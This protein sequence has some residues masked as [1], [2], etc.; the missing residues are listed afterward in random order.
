VAHDN[1]SAYEAADRF[2]LMRV[3]STS[4]L[5]QTAYQFFSGTASAPAWVSYSNRAQ[6][7]AIFT[8]KGRCLRNGMTYH[9]ARKRYY[10]WQQ[11]PPTK[12]DPDTRL[13]GGFGIYSAANP[14]GPWSPVYYTEKW[15]VGPGDRGEFPTK[16]MGSQG[17]N[18]SGD[19]YLSFS[20]NDSFSI[21]KGTISANH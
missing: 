12:F 4:I 8:C 3:P 6:R 2:I 19:M 13:F 20:G 7:T 14:W 5:D 10:W 9:A 18:A 11:I 1:R 15:G 16:W 17:I 21:R